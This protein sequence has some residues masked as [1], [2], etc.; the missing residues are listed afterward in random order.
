MRIGLIYEYD[1]DLINLL[2]LL[3]Y[4]FYYFTIDSEE[5]RR[6]YN[7][8]LLPFNA[9]ESYYKDLD[10][11]INL[12]DMKISLDKVIN[13]IENPEKIQENNNKI[14]V[15]RNERISKDNIIYFPYVI[16]GKISSSKMDK[17]S[18][19]K[20][21]KV[22]LII[23]D[24][25]SIEM[26]GLVSILVDEFEIYI[27]GIIDLNTSNS[28]NIYF[29]KRKLEKNEL[30][31]LLSYVDIIL[32]FSKERFF[33]EILYAALLK[34]PILTI[35]KFKNFNRLIID[36]NIKKRIINFINK[37]H[38]EYNISENLIENAKEIIDFELKRLENVFSKK[39]INILDRK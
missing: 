18:V 16:D 23:C 12:S 29:I 39:E 5:I 14:Y 7:I 34:K 30:I 32:D 13:K 8:F 19:N 25:I 1:I 36:E 22:I 4:E 35:K 28:K 3:N 26:V 20:R 11:I 21:R 15:Y 6:F 31:K 33:K 27:Y 10:F 24:K 9:M 38:F 37:K 2:R 17:I